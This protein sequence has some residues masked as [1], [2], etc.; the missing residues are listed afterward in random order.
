MIY[1]GRSDLLSAVLQVWR[2]L[3]GEQNETPLNANHAF[4]GLS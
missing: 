3:L 1:Y 2:V 4:P